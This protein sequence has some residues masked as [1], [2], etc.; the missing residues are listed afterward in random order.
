MNSA[1]I[2][3]KCGKNQKN[4]SEN[5]KIYNGTES[6]IY[7]VRGIRIARD[8]APYKDTQYPLLFLQGQ[9]CEKGLP[10]SVGA[11]ILFIDYKVVSESVLIFYVLYGRCAYLTKCYF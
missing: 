1:K 5:W 7:V 3:I 4:L 2:T 10:R 9:G 8:H 11:L 6:F